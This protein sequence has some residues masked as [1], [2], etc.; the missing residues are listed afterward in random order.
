MKFINET[1]G[2]KTSLG[3]EL[4][5]E[6]GYK[7]GLRVD[8]PYTVSVGLKAQV[9]SSNILEAG[10]IDNTLRVTFH[11]GDVYEYSGVP[12]S[13]YVELVGA[14]SVGGY[15]NKLVKGVYTCFKLEEV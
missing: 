2:E 7:F 3:F 15:F 14:D 4:E 12:I 8:A 9:D 13:V 1:D 10:Y 5:L 11:N 6:E